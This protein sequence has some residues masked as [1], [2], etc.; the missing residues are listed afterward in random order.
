M[1]P[2]TKMTT[3]P[4]TESIQELL[5][6]SRVHSESSE[7][8]ADSTDSGGD[9]II[10]QGTA[11][12][13]LQRMS[14]RAKIATTSARDAGKTTYDFY[15]QVP[16]GQGTVVYVMDT[17]VRASHVDFEGRVEF[18]AV[19][20]GCESSFTGISSALIIIALRL[21]FSVPILSSR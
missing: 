1:V 12:W 17:G 6:P 8:S 13:N 18:A 5:D 3:L 7:D 10:Q 15:H 2:D 21:F 11:P 16:D 19:F 14:Q 20:G 9:Y 4:I